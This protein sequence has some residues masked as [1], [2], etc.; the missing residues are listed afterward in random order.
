MGIFGLSIPDGLAFGVAPVVLSLIFGWAAWVTLATA[1]LKG[2][3]EKVNDHEARLR[4][5]EAR[6]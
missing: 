3:D 6:R 2:L 4:A 5:L 1:G